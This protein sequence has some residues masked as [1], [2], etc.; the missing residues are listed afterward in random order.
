MA[1]QNLVVISSDSLEYVEEDDVVSPVHSDAGSSPNVS[2]VSW[3][4]SIFGPLVSSDFE[5]VA[6]C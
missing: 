1:H 2:L 3:D 6:Y 4:S 5:S